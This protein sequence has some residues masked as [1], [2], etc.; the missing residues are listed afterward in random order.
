MGKKWCN[1]NI[2]CKHPP[3]HQATPNQ[4]KSHRVPKLIQHGFAKEIEAIKEQIGGTE[5]ETATRRVCGPRG[6]L[7]KFEAEFF[8]RAVSEASRDQ[9]SEYRSKAQGRRSHVGLA[10]GSCVIS[11]R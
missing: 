7:S 8:L 1:I 9:V 2:R 6:K 11:F 10:Y 5:A 3:L 4:T